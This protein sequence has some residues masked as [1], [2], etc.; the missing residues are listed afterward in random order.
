MLLVGVVTRDRRIGS[1]TQS[2]DFEIY[3]YNSGVVGS[4]FS[5]KEVA[6][7]GEQTRGLSISLIFFFSQ[8]QQQPLSHSGSLAL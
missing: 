8:L 4:F 5:S 6:R 2:Y 3:N 7:S 1:W